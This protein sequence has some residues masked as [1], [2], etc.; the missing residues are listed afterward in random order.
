MREKE[1]FVGIRIGKLIAIRKWGRN[2]SSNQRWLFRCDCGNYTPVM[3]GSLGR[4]TTDCGHCGVCVNDRGDYKKNSPYCSLHNIW[5]KMRQRCNNP[6]NGDY[7]NYGGRGIEVCNKWNNSYS[8]FKK[9]ALDNDWRPNRTQ[10]Y[11]SIDRID[12]DGCYCPENCRWVDSKT[13]NRNRRD[14]VWIDFHGE[15][16][17]LADLAEKYGIKQYIIGRRYKQGYREDDLILPPNT[18]PRRFKKYN[19]K[20][21]MLTVEEISLKLNIN[22]HAVRSRIYKGT[23]N[24]N[25]KTKK[26]TQ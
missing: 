22:E 6:N 19:F 26:E 3:V 17:V 25:K 20:N 10:K 23:L 18:L 14:N 1:M 9:W 15:K 11:Q 16:I 8:E 7:H 4:Y 12:V 21:E 13:Q 2:K 24:K 5:I